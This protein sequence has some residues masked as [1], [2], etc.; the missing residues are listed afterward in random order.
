MAS[1]TSVTG[2][3]VGLTHSASDQVQFKNIDSQP[4]TAADLGP[5][6]GSYPPSPPPI[7]ATASPTGT[8]ISSPG[9]TAGNLN[10]GQ[11]SKKYV[12]DVPG[13]YVFGCAYHYLSNNMRTVIIVQ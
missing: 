3:V 13:V 7:T 5:W 9:F 4:H 1:V 8:D 10:P 2:A 12:A 11:K 6:S